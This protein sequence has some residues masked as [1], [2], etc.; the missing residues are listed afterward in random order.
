[1]LALKSLYRSDM[2]F[3]TLNTAYDI[4]NFHFSVYDEEDEIAKCWWASGQLFL[5]CTA[6]ESVQ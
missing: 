4:S 6:G 3:V 1:M 2:V 5:S